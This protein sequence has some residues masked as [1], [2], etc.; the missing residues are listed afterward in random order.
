MCLIHIRL[1]P[2]CVSLGKQFALYNTSQGQYENNFFDTYDRWVYSAFRYTQNSYTCK[3]FLAYVRPIVPT[4]DS[5]RKKLYS[6]PYSSVPRGVQIPL[7]PK[8][9]PSALQNRAKINPV[10]KTVKIVEF[11]TPTPQDVREKGS[12][13]LKLP[14]VRNCFTLATTNT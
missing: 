1:L 10:V 2:E 5:T 12:K 8:K 14:P 6:R 13:I 11:R 7:P 3:L 9:I 4:Y